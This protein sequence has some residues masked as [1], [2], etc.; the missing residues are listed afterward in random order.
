MALKSRWFRWM[1]K[2]ED[3]AGAP[4]EEAVNKAISHSASLLSSV[5][6]DTA[7]QWNLVRTRIE[8]SA[9]QKA[10]ARPEILH[11]WLKPALAVGLSAAV[12]VAIVGYSLLRSVPPILYQTGVAQTSSVL[13]ADSSEVILNHHSALAVD[14]KGST[15]SRLTTL[16]GEAFFKVHRNGSPFVVATDIGSVTVLGT[17]FNVRVRRGEMEVA[18]VTG[19]VSVTASRD[20]RDSTVILQVG[21]YTVLAK[22]GYPALPQRLPFA[23]NYPGWIHGKFL[24]NHQS[25]ASACG[26][27]AEQFG[28]RVEI[29]NS[30]I[31]GETIT[32]AIDGRSVESAV[33]TLSL[34][35]GTSYRYENNGYILY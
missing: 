21:E 1:G 29:A 2:P 20:G 22:G 16:T 9:E 24:L 6:T 15:G 4:S 13:L 17:E 31:A 26:E 18:V 7:R 33:K 11:H 5:D 3:K 32:G 19:K 30:A 12:L 25:L 10:V 14:L 27:I 34:L 28:I 23:D 8:P 35:S